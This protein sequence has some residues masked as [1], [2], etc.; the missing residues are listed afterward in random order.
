LPP[1]WW[2]D[3]ARPRSPGLL[4]FSGERNHHGEPDTRL[5]YRHRLDHLLHGERGWTKELTNT[6]DPDL[7][8][9]HIQFAACRDAL[10]GIVDAEIRLLPHGYLHRRT[11][12]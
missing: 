7:R 3:L 6:T 5:L 11:V 2:D 9:L 8:K 4:S 12:G 1:G 10:A